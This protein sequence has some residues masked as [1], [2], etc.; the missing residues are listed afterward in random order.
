METLNESGNLFTLP[1]PP[2]NIS[3]LLPWILWRMVAIATLYVA[4]Q[5][6]MTLVAMDTVLSDPDMASCLCHNMK[7][8]I[9]HFFIYHRLLLV[10]MATTMCIDPVF[11]TIVFMCTC[12][13]NIDDKNPICNHFR[14]KKYSLNY[15]IFTYI[16]CENCI[17]CLFFYWIL[18]H[19]FGAVAGSWSLYTRYFLF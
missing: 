7:K 17:F 5:W 3:A 13:V 9:F 14:S 19:I 1:P 6:L 12:S 2:W 18:R 15:T 16:F 11:H 4:Y 10:T 8:W